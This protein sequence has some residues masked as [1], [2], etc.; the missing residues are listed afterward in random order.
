MAEK[1]RASTEKISEIKE[2]MK[3][4]AVLAKKDFVS[5]CEA[6]TAIRECFEAKVAERFK[7]ILQSCME[8]GRQS[9][10]EVEEQIEKLQD[11]GIVY[12]KVEGENR[13]VTTGN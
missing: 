2:E 7:E 13:D 12:E 5:A 8:E 1:I 6:G 9:F 10:T 4:A 3:Q 11:I